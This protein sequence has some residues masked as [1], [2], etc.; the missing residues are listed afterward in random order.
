MHDVLEDTGFFGNA[1]YLTYQQLIEE[2]RYRISLP[3]GEETAGIVIDVSKPNGSDMAGKTTD[4]ID[5]MYH[6]NLENVPAKSLL[7]KMADVLHNNRTFSLTTFKKQHHRVEETERVYLD[8]F[9]RKVLPEYPNEGQYLLD[10]IKLAINK[11]R[12]SWQNTSS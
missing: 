1:H 3:F 8:M 5:D 6:K 10:Q 12:L 11:T 7:V 4:E 9:K 2:A